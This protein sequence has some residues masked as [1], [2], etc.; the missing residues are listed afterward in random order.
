MKKKQDEMNQQFEVFFQ[1]EE[2]VKQHFGAF[3]KLMAYYK[4]AMMEIE[5]KF[6]VLNVEFS[7]RFDRNPISSIKTRMNTYQPHQTEF[8][9]KRISTITP[10]FEEQKEYCF[11]M[12]D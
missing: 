4:C 6:N 8:G 7:L 1:S 3:A 9:M 5:T 11:Q 12:M 2:N 10:D